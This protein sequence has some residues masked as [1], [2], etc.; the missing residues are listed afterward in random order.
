MSFPYSSELFLDHASSFLQI[1]CKE[2]D[3]RAHFGGPSIAIE[4]LWNQIVNRFTEVLPSR[5][6]MNSFLLS[7]AYIKCPC[8]TLITNASRFHIDYR[9]MVIKTKQTCILIIK[10][11]PNVYIHSFSSYSFLINEF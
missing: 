4:Y 8:P 3:F 5:W 2:S 7:L 9:T 1:N 11:L 6:N 10:T